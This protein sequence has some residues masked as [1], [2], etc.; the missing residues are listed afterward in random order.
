MSTQ[1]GLNRKVWMPRRAAPSE[2]PEGYSIV[3]NFMTM[4]T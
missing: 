2:F 3:L 1:T 4:S